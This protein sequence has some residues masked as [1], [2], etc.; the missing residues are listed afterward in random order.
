MTQFANKGVVLA[1]V[2]PLLDGAVPPHRVTHSAPDRIE[3]ALDEGR[4]I[5]LAV[6]EEGDALRFDI[7]VCGL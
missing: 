3:W 4:T 6:G 1:D 5:T 2:Q 7:S